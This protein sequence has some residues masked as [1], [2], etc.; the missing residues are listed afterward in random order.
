MSTEKETNK[1][2]LSFADKEMTRRQFMKISGKTLAG[3]TLSAGMLSLLGACQYQIDEGLITVT[4]LT[5]GLLV[6]NK[7]VCSGCV[8]C[9]VICTTLKDGHVSTHNARLKVTRN[10]MTNANGVGMYHDLEEGW[11]C[12]P[13]TCRQC[14]DPT[15]CI[16]ACPPP[17]RAAGAIINDNGVIKITDACVGCG[18]C[19]PACPWGMIVRNTVTGFPTKCDN[20]GECIKFCPTGALKFIEWSDVAAAAQ[21]HWQG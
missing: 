6:V 2:L 10:L 4:A 18:Q 1:G 19:I 15:Y 8:R 3:V 5:E 11:A 17:F 14:Q 16:D 21:A 20:C 9:E 12:Y 7:D 13:D